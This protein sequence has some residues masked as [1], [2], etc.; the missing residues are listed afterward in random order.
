MA[1]VTKKTSTTKTT[2][3]KTASA[4]KASVKPD[5]PKPVRKTVKEKAAVTAQKKKI[6]M[7]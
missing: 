4:T 1:T 3:K 7:K 5:A 6:T 2:T